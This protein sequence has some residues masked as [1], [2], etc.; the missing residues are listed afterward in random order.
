MSQGR[1]EIQTLAQFLTDGASSDQS[2]EEESSEEEIPMKKP[3][4]PVRVCV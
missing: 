2:S 4:K 1:V 3:K